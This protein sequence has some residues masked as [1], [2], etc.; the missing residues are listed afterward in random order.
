MSEQCR[1]NQVT[2]REIGFVCLLDRDT[3]CFA[4]WLYG[5]V[6]DRVGEAVQMVAVGGSQRPGQCRLRQVG[7]ISDRFDPKS[8]QSRQS[9]RPDTPQGTGGQRMQI[10]QL[11]P[12]RNV[13]EAVGF[14][15]LRRQLGQ[16]LVRCHTDRR[17]KAQIAPYL[18]SHRL[19]HF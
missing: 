11:T 8:L 19:A 2:S 9:C 4:V 1:L 17:R 5:S 3:L 10:L 13:M 14:R 18:G 6:V 12:L 7:D 16:E 15:L